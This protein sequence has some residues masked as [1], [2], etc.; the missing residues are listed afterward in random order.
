MVRTEK[1]HLQLVRRV[2]YYGYTLFNVWMFNM[3]CLMHI[4]NIQYIHTVRVKKSTIS[5]KE[6]EQ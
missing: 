4:R 3:K 1:E 6:I 2:L 5:E